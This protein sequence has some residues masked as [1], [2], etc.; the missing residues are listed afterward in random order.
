MENKEREVDEYLNL[1]GKFLLIFDRTCNRYRR[2]ADHVQE[3][4]EDQYRILRKFISENKFVIERQT[5]QA[6]SRINML[7][8][9]WHTHCRISRTLGNPLKMSDISMTIV[10]TSSRVLISVKGNMNRSAIPR[11]IAPEIP[12]AKVVC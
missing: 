2:M 12:L 7:S 4:E 8:N 10:L 1:T 6:I 5:S 11:A 3:L 9:S